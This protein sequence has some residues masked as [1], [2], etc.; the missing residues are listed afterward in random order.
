MIALDR[1]HMQRAHPRRHTVLAEGEIARAI[2]EQTMSAPLPFQRQ[3]ESGIAAD[4]DPL[5]WVHLD[6]DSQGHGVFPI[7][8]IIGAP[9]I[10]QMQGWAERRNGDYIKPRAPFG[11]P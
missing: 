11:Q 5:D 1:A 4:I 7:R 2:I 10:A 3:R 9:D 6:S 8:L